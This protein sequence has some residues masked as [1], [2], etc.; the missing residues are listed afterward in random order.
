M[1]EHTVIGDILRL[2]WWKTA[3]RKAEDAEWKILED[4]ARDEFERRASGKGPGQWVFRRHPRPELNVWNRRW[5]DLATGKTGV[6]T[7][8]EKAPSTDTLEWWF[9]TKKERAEL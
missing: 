6:V 8:Y 2:P 1:L 9:P 3:K 7:G 5:R 4:I